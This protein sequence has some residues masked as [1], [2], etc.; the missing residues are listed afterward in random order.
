MQASPSPSPS[1]SSDSNSDSAPAEPDRAARLHLL[2]RATDPLPAS[3]LEQQRHDGIERLRKLLE[4]DLLALSRRAS[5]DDFADIYLGFLAEIERFAA[6]CAYPELSGRA[7]VA[8]GGGFSVGKSSL[9]NALIG[10]SVLPVQIDPTTTLPAYVLA[11][12]TDGVCA[13]NLYAQ[14]IELNAAEFASLTHDE[15]ERHGTQI[16]RLLQAAFVGRSTFPWPRL[17]F[18]DTPGFRAGTLG[19]QADAARAQMQLDAAQAVLWVLPIKQ[20]TVPETDLALLARLRPE[21]PKLIVLSGADLVPEADRERI[22]AQ[23]Q[24]VLRT[25]NLAVQAVL[26][27]SRQPKY[28]ALLEPL[29]AQLESWQALAHDARFAHRFKA[30]FVRYAR[31]LQAERQAAELERHHLN[32]LLT[33]VPEAALPD[34]LPLRQAADARSQLR[35]AVLT[36]LDT[37]RN[38]FFTELAQIGQAVGVAL[39]QPHEIDLI[40]IGGEPRLRAY[41]AALAQQPAGATP[42]SAPASAAAHASQIQ[43]LHRALHVL[44]QP[45]APTHAPGLLRRQRLAPTALAAL[46]QPATPTHAPRLLRRQRLAPTALAALRQSAAPT[47]APGLLRRQRLAPTALSVLQTQ[48]AAP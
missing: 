28:R 2:A 24:Q 1:P 47:H 9:L 43:A 18:I 20:G 4:T 29:A 6:F 14:R 45:A 40:D 39:P 34:A 21:Q 22:V 30:L 48:G 23:V 8:V 13:L 36:E 11:A 37:L 25:R 10:A 17:A 44:R 26:P 15:R 12:P 19:T 5:P 46:R 42:A 16:G 31:G 41:L 33:L 7:L 32:R 38:R 3:A 35:A 27:V